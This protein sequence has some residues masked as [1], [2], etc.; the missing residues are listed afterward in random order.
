MPETPAQMPS[1]FARSWGGKVTVMIDSVPGMSSAPPTPCSARA[2]ISWVGVVD[3]PHANE[4]TV[5]TTSPARNI[6][7]RP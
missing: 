5:K 6:R 3:R 1:A 4:N 7:L 2:T